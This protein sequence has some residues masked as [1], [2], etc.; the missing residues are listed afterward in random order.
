MSSEFEGAAVSR[1]DVE[2]RADG[3]SLVFA[4]HGFSMCVDLSHSEAG[5]LLDQLV[6]QPPGSTG[7]RA[8]AEVDGH[9]PG[10]ATR[11]AAGVG[12]HAVGG[13]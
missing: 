8:G 11:E 2:H 9:E 3:V 13:E 5:D 7:Q 10:Q 12:C 1:I 4:S 6:Q